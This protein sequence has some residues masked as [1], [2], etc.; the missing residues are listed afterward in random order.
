MTYT[1]NSPI[2]RLQAGDTITRVA[3]TWLRN[4][5]MSS[6]NHQQEP[7]L[8]AH[9][10]RKLEVTAPNGAKYTS[11]VE[12]ENCQLVCFVPPQAGTYTAKVTVMSRPSAEPK[13]H[14]GLAFY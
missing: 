12:K 1:G 7:S 13:I 2:L 11:Y 14:I 10:K 6:S 3:L 5:R 8:A 9:A 4:N